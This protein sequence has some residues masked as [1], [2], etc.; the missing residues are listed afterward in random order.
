MPEKKAAFLQARGKLARGQVDTQG[1][2]L[3]FFL[4]LN[5]GVQIKQTK[6]PGI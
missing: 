6:H 1:T 2:N 3:F 5:I 4:V